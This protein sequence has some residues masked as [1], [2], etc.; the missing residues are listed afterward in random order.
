M[1]GPHATSTSLSLC[2][3]RSRLSARALIDARP[4]DCADPMGA[5]GRGLRTSVHGDWRRGGAVTHVYVTIPPPP[6][7]ARPPRHPSIMLM[8][9]LSKLLQYQCAMSTRL[10]VVLSHDTTMAQPSLPEPKASG[11]TAG[12]FNVQIMF[13]RSSHPPPSLRGVYCL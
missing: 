10:Q 13:K 5:R 2:S 1:W 7:S 8:A 9:R 12:A 4:I 3:R 11:A 6:P